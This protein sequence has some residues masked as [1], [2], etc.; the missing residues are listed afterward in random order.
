MVRDRLASWTNRLASWRVI[1]KSLPISAVDTPSSSRAAVID[2]RRARRAASNA[3]SR[4]VRVRLCSD[5]FDR[6]F[7]RVYQF[8]GRSGGADTRKI[9]A[10]EFLKCYVSNSIGAIIP[11]T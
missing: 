11:C 7:R 2:T 5:E 9:R 8:Y 6:Y 3:S 4:W 10:H 1:P